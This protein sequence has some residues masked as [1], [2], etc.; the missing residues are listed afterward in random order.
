MRIGTITFHKTTNYGATLQAYALQRHLIE[1]G[2]EA[3]LID[4]LSNTGSNAARRPFLQ[5]VVNRLKYR[6]Y[7]RRWSANNEKFI[8]FRQNFLRLGEQTY[9]GDQ[10][11][12]S[13][14]PRYDAYIAGSD[15]IWNTSLSNN[16]KA[17]YLS[18]AHQGKRISY[19]ASFGKKSFGSGEDLLID[20][21]VKGF[22]AVSVREEVHQKMLM[23][24]YGIKAEVVLDPVFL[25]D[26]DQWLSMA[27]DR[28]NEPPYLLVYVL[29]ENG[30]MYA[31][32]KKKARE[33][34]LEVKYLSLIRSSVPGKA[35]SG[36][37][38]SEF[39]RLM[40]DAN[41][42]CTNSF[43]GTAFSIILEKEFTVFR[44]KTRNSRI[45]NI[46]GI[47]G[48]KHR[49]GDD[50]HDTGTIDY[51]KVR[52]ALEPSITASKA[53]LEKALDQ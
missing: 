7:N 39:I 26:K 40:L 36:L 47:T 1:Q 28:T 41:Y 12:E 48:L 52:K 14:P 25:L 19:A 3:E 27:T 6:D 24:R 22:D 38:P 17:F 15:Q 4:Y 21:Y 20:N 31:Y 49:Y 5:R 53:Y 35:L 30:D 37:G 11:I 45:D 50:G 13:Q 29:E 2:H 9:H 18:F 8:A 34:G 51:L 33:L 10:A 42:I 16:S 44:H 23:D 46:L 32:A 43:H